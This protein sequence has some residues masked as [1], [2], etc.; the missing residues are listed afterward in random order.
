MP[1]GQENDAAAKGRTILPMLYS[2]K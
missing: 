1:P 2:D